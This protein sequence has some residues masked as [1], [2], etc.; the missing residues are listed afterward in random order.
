MSPSVMLPDHRLAALLQQVK[1][2]QVNECLFHTSAAQPSLYADHVCDRAHFPSDL[3]F[4]LDNHAKE[5]WQVRF[6]HN[7][8]RLASCGAD[9]FI[10]I[11][12]VPSFEIL[13]KLEGH[14]GGV[15]NLA[16][17]PDDSLIVS[18]GVDRFAKV[19]DVKVQCNSH[20]LSLVHL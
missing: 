19:W 14:E 6:S 13:Y 17:S 8:T 5:V 7:G 1:E 16:W 2:N 3:L 12:D 4:E 10:L 18:C 9:P 20:G 11:F 15:G